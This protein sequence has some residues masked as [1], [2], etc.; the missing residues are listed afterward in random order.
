MWGSTPVGGYPS[1]GDTLTR[2]GT[3]M[4]GSMYGNAL[5]RGNAHHGTKSRYRAWSRKRKKV[6]KKENIL[7]LTHYV[8][9]V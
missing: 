9:K 7:Y 6:P 5:P 2:G 4:Y 8:R 3:A 1:R